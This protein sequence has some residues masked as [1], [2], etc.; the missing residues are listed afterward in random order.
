MVNMNSWI[1][2]QISEGNIGTQVFFLNIDISWI[3]ITKNEK[4][5]CLCW[6][7]TLAT[8]PKNK[9]LKIDPTLNVII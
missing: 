1:F 8:P 3:Y 6:L 9:I 4:Y 2:F 7:L 5:L